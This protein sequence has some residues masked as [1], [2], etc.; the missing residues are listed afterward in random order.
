MLEICEDKIIDYLRARISVVH[1]LLSSF[2]VPL[3]K[4][5]EPMIMRYRERFNQ[6]TAWE[7]TE[8]L[9]NELMKYNEEHK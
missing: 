6:P 8:Y 4:K 5:W 1:D 2:L 7:G 3:W 9:Y